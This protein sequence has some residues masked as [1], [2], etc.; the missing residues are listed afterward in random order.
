MF[1]K[2]GPVA[3]LSHLDTQKAV[4]RAIKRAELPVAF[5]QGFNPHQLTG[6]G[7]PLSTGMEAENEYFEIEL[8]EEMDVSE[9]ALR[10]NVCLPEGIEF[11]GG[12]SVRD[13]EK[14]AAS[15]VCAAEYEFSYE[16]D[17]KLAASLARCIVEFLAAD[18]I[19]SLKKTKD[20]SKTVEIRQ[21]VL[22]FED[23]SVG[24]EIKLRLVTAAGSLKS[25]KPALAAEALFELAGE[26]YKG[27]KA[28]FLR[29]KI[30]LAE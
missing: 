19:F 7:L 5:S 8:A 13:G 2:H 22:E 6:F 23:I 18:E 1:R 16:F 12:R 11:F 4:Q 14:T 27:F 30:L 21:A 17:E 15:L 24:N 25:L 3:F 26:E 9:A 20:G 28:R 29:K 10:L